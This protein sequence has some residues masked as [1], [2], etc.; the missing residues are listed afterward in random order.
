MWK[1]IA[2]IG[3]SALVVI[4]ISLYAYMRVEVN[5]AKRVIDAQEPELAKYR[6]MGAGVYTSKEIILAGDNYGPSYLISR[7]QEANYENKSGNCDR[8]FSWDSTTRVLV[9][10]HPKSEQGLEPLYQNGVVTV[11]FSGQKVASVSQGKLIIPP[12]FLRQIDNSSRQNLSGDENP[13]LKEAITKAE[14]AR[15]FEHGGVDYIALAGAIVSLA[16]FSA[17][18]KSHGTTI[19]MQTAKGLLLQLQPKS[20]TKQWKAIVYAKALEEKFDKD[21]IFQMYSNYVYLGPDTYGFRAALQKYFCVSIEAATEEQCAAVAGKLRLPG[22]YEPTKKNGKKNWTERTNQVLAAMGSKNRVEEKFFARAQCAVAPARFIVRYVWDQVGKVGDNT[23]IETTLNPYIQA[24]LEDAVR[25]VGNL[26]QPNGGKHGTQLLA[27]AL[28]PKTGHILGEAQKGKYTGNL[29]NYHFTG[30]SVG[31][32]FVYAAALTEGVDAMNKPVP[33]L[34]QD[35]EGHTAKNYDHKY[36]GN[37][38]WYKALV[39]SRN[40]PAVFIGSELG[41]GKLKST[42]EVLGFSECPGAYP[43]IAEGQFGMSVVELALAYSTFANGGRRPTEAVVTPKEVNFQTHFSPEAIAQVNAAQRDILLEGTLAKAAKGLGGFRGVI[44]GKTGSATEGVVVVLFTENLVVVVWAGSV[45]NKPLKGTAG[46]IV[47]PIGVR[48]FQKILSAMPRFLGS[49]KYNATVETEID[50]SPEPTEVP[51]E[52]V[53]R[54]D[55][56]SGGKQPNTS[57]EE[58]K[59]IKINP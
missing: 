58:P 3:A 12:R 29:I 48:I 49:V 43:T 22:A 42:Y 28:D 14:D 55:S 32:P 34:E 30:G 17:D 23:R 56:E 13:K 9:V 8:C 10:K 54:P 31:K 47:G 53:I 21:G 15:F 39:L 18:Q 41:F 2:I 45:E 5:E 50:A 37:M 38:P 35:I 40:P 57:K 26:P 52:G 51:E 59:V 4:A 33:D 46:T 27:I 44:F 1:K 7:L 6:T 20:Y 24:V 19:S 11:N 16:D 36:L 25:G